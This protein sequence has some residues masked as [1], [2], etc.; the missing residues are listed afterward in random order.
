[1]LF[2]SPNNNKLKNDNETSFNEKISG[3][4]LL[5]CYLNKMLTF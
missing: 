1:M 2:F 4:L 5:T 3:I